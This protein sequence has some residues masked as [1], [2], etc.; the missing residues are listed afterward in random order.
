M[1]FSVDS[2]NISR[3]LENAALY[4]PNRPALSEAGNEISFSEFITSLLLLAAGS[5]GL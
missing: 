3:N 2:M 5:C 4:F 1:R